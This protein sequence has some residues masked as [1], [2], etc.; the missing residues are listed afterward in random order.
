MGGDELLGEEG[1]CAQTREPRSS[2][3]A[4]ADGVP[5]LP[6]LMRYGR[7]A[8]SSTISSWWRTWKKRGPSVTVR[9]P[10]EALRT[11]TTCTP[12]G[13]LAD[14]LRALGW[15]G[16]ALGGEQCAAWISTWE[17]EPAQERAARLRPWE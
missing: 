4:A 11:G 10:R 7:S 14:W 3:N 9:P 13:H 1:P 16:Q 2:V 8:L 15:D 5:V 17:N 12:A 6:S